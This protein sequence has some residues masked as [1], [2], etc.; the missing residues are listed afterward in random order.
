MKITR[1]QL[2]QLINEEVGIISEKIDVSKALEIFRNIGN[3]A[4]DIS[5]F[6]DTNFRALG[7]L[8]TKIVEEATS[9]PGAGEKGL[10]NFHNKIKTY[11]DSLESKY[12]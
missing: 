6:D 4:V 9:L 7:S 3:S 2:R 11:M 5:K 12:K 8:L 10:A 1:R